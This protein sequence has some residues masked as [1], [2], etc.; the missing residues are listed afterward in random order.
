MGISMQRMGIV[1][2]KFVT[3]AL[4]AVILLSVSVASAADPHASPD[5]HGA[6]VHESPAQGESFGEALHE[7]ENMTAEVEGAHAAPHGD[8]HADAAHGDAH[9][10]AH[11][12]GGLPQFDPST[13]PSQLFWLAV[14]FITMYV[15][16]SRRSLPAISSVIENRREHV[17]ND[18]ETAERL[19]TEA[20]SVQQ[21]YETGLD[22]ARNESTRLVTAAIEDMKR[23]AETANNRLREKSESETA[24]LE[25]RLVAATQAARADME[26]IAAEIA[27]EA[28]EKVFGISTDL[29]KAKTVVQSI[30]AREAA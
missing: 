8:G 23:D 18:L 7:Q 28:A 9:G 29:K 21:A 24:A 1:S 3:V 20:E 10:E 30:N 17:Q 26:T 12:K 5:S 13:F 25:Q 6:T 19:R 11:G 27:H 22:T 16:F 15:V 4:A 2:G 14:M